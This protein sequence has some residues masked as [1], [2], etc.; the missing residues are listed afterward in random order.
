MATEVVVQSGTGLIQNVEARG[1]H[2]VVD[3]PVEAGGTGAGPTP[4]EL[5]LGALGACTALTL[6]MYAGRKNWPLEA[7]QV[8][9]S[10]D[11]VYA[12]DCEECDAA[13]TNAYLD[14]IRKRIVLEGPLTEEQR[15]RLLDI[16]ERCPVQRTLQQSV[17]IAADQT[18]SPGD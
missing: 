7:V 14:R 1:H 12:R 5:L 8:H 2:I 15:A 18:V 16:A 9:L 6:R 11:R 4:Y 17:V 13:D 10:H 3:E